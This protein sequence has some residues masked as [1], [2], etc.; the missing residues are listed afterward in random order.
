[1]NHFLNIAAKIIAILCAILFVATALAALFFS[2]ME[3]RAFDPNTYKV[4]LANDNF[5]QSLPSLLSQVLAKE[6]SKNHTPFVQQLTAEDWTTVIQILLPPEQLRNMTEDGI[7]QI[8]A[9]LN[10]ETSDPHLS[11]LPLK[12]RLSGSAG[13]DAATALIHAQPNCTVAQ[14]AQLIASF[15]QV[16]CNPPQ[17][18]LSIGK[19]VIQSQLDSIAATL[20]DQMSLAGTSNSIGL[21]NLRYLRLMM[22]LSPLIPL[23]FLFAV[24]IFAVRTFKGWLTW[25]GWPFLVTGVAGA[26]LGFSGLQLFRIAIENVISRRMQLRIPPE[27]SNA[28]R[29][30]MDAVFR[31]IFQSAGWQAVIIAVIGLIMIVIAFIISQREK[32]QRIQR[33]EA[34]TQIQR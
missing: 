17:D 21:R 25:W 15:G 20:P 9:Y 10:G 6:A 33:A 12:Q 26:V 14:L 28:I 24:T 13:I 32:T 7:T 11:L 27:F 4:A 5:Y 19:P 23:I 34:E 18:M 22:Q 16:L 3:Q 31:E 1:M 30:V 2:N 29:A 8:F